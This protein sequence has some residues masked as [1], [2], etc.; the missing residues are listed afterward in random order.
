M[1]VTPEDLNLTADRTPS[2]QI[3]FKNGERESHVS[4]GEFNEL[5][6]DIQKYNSQ[7][8]MGRMMA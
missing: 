6:A 5:F 3:A 1:D 2:Q 7:F 8:S 4:V